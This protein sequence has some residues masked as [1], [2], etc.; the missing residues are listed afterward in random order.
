M[1]GLITEYSYIIDHTPSAILEAELTNL[2]PE[3]ME[4]LVLPEL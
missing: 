1:A 3:V 4:R 2:E